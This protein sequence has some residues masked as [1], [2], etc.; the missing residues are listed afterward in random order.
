MPCELTSAITSKTRSTTWGARPIDGSSSISSFGL[1][2]S[3]RPIASI[4]CSPPESVPPACLRRSLSTREELED[5]IEVGVQLL[6]GGLPPLEGAH[7]EVLVDA[8]VRED[9]PAL[10]N[11][12]DA[13]A[14]TS[15]LFSDVMSSPLKRIWP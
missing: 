3:A 7:L 12:D 9:V 15:W 13:L 10:G 6:L 4:C 1:A 5:V 8:H 11:L 2:I 14:T